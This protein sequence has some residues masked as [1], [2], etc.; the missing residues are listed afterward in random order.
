MN[1]IKLQKFA[2]TKK[3]EKCLH[4]LVSDLIFFII[5]LYFFQGIVEP[6]QAFKRGGRAA[7]GAYG[8][9]KPAGS[10]VSNLLFGLS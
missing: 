2:F 5:I 9:E 1:N 6:V 10:D 7:I 8:T 4:C 3:I